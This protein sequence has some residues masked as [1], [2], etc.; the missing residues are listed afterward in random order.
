MK[1]NSV[2]GFTWGGNKTWAE[3]N[4][5][6]GRNA[7]ACRTGASLISCAKAFTD[8]DS[9]FHKFLNFIETALSGAGSNQQYGIYSGENDDL[10]EDKALR[11]HAAGF[12]SIACF[13]E[14]YI[15]PFLLPF[16]TFFGEKFSEG[17]STISHLANRMW[18][19]F[20]PCIKKIDI[21]K[22]KDTLIYDIKDLLNQERKKSALDRIQ[23]KLPPLLGLIGVIFS[24]IFDPLKA[25]YKISG[26]EE[27]WASACSAIASTSQNI[28]YFFKLSLEF[29]FK[30]QE[31][32][33]KNDLF[34]FC[35][36]SSANAT[37]AVLPIVELFPEG[38]VKSVLK[39]LA[40]GLLSTFFS[41]RRNTIGREWL[42]CNKQKVCV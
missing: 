34:L 15:N 13:L 25:F 3:R 18:W 40:A 9:S 17:V 37:N 16:S 42:E 27:R 28:Y 32:K 2:N 31:K 33:N 23:N 29:L 20:R 30:Y 6:K 1:V 35:L 12:G 19:R 38:K 10:E 36:G 14:K 7:L 39:T 8:Q 26:I 5:T 4:I 11:P 41:Y 21:K 24:A 22:L